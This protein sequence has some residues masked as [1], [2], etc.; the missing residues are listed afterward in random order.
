MFGI[1]VFSYGIVAA[2]LFL[3]AP[4]FINAHGV[5][6][7][8]VVA[9]TEDGYEVDLGYDPLTLMEDVQTRFSFELFDNESTTT[10]SSFTEVWVVIK[11]EEGTVF[12]SG[13]D[14]PEFGEIGMSFTFPSSGP[15]DIKLRYQEDSKILAT[16]TFTLDVAPKPKEGFGTT[17]YFAAGGAIGFLLGLI[18]CALFKRRKRY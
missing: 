1:R 8:S 4:F 16:H 10:L 5:G 7:E 12:S 2:C 9:I 6:Y 3:V 17:A 14:R 18:I 11:G 13:I 15:H